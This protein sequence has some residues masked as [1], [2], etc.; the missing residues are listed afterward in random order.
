MKRT[1]IA[2]WLPLT[3]VSMLGALL[4]SA[5]PK[6]TGT[7]SDAYVPPDSEACTDRCQ[8]GER[9]CVTGGY[10]P[11]GNFNA[12]E[13]LEW[14]PMVPCNQGEQCVDGVC[15][16]TTL[17]NECI[18]GSA[19]CTA[20]GTGT[21]TCEFNNGL[22][23][24]VWGAVVPCGGGETCSCAVC[25]TVCVDECAPGSRRC[26][27][28][29]YQVCGDFD[30]DT[31]Q[32]WGPIIPCSGNETCSDGACGTECVH[33]CTAGATR[34]SCTGHTVQS[35]GDFDPDPCLEWGPEIPCNLGETCSNGICSSSCQDECSGVG[36]TQCTPSGGAYQECDDHNTDGCL[37]W[38]PEINCP[39]DQTCV[40]GVCGEHCDCDNQS[41]ICEAG[42]PNS[43]TPCA[44]DPDCGTPC[45]SDIYCDPWCPSGNDPDCSGCACDFNEYC[46]AESQGS[47]NTCTCDLDCEPHE[48]ACM[49]DAHCDSW[50]PAGADPD[51]G[52]ADPCRSRYM[53]VGWRNANE[54]YKLGSYNDPDPDEGSPWVELSP[55]MSSGGVWVIVQFSAENISC[56]DGIMVEAWGYDDST[57]GDGAEMY[58]WDWNA[59][60]YDLLP[61]ETINH[62]LG[63]HTNSVINPLP[64]VLCGSGQGAKCYIDF[65]IEASAWDNTH[66]WDAYVYVHMS[67]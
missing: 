25:R 33:E 45:G 47:T 50:C 22:G 2:H 56:V 13:C 46:E 64:Y 28:D 29:G 18:Q 9:Q 10:Q 20:N 65:K 57:F 38:G 62:T 21:Q 54:M 58:L 1:S 3:T 12:D 24:W 43:T 42:A 37:E 23:V 27:D 5:C 48:S 30:G 51:C 49:D 35:C 7:G 67:P 4:L 66:V 59:T 34:C 61:D 40:N 39:Q 14:G 44:C 32:D 8:Q 15:E 53:L 11:C 60:N 19:K 41:G 52:G 55:G 16:P 63:W 36:A 17:T 6:N 26:S 31:C